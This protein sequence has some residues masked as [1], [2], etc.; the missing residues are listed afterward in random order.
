VAPAFPGATLEIDAEGEITHAWLG[1]AAPHLGPDRGVLAALGI[2]DAA[3][4]AAQVQMLL[5]STI[6]APADAWPIFVTDAPATLTRRDGQMLAVL[7]APVIT[8]GTITRVVVFVIPTAVARAEEED[9]AEVNRI[10]VDALALVDDSQAAL[11]HLTRDPHAR[12]CVHRMFRNLHTIKGSTRGPRLQAI[13]TL[14][15]D[16]EAVVEILQRTAEAEPHVLAQVG[17]HLQRLRAMIGTARPR[18]EVDD[19]MSELLGEC[20]PALVDLQLAI[21]RLLADDADAA[22]IAS[23]AIDQIQIAS[24]RAGMQ[25]LHQQCRFAAESV[26]AIARGAPITPARIDEIT[27]LDRQVELYA[28]VYRE[29][30]ASDRGPSLILTIASWIGSPE[31][32][33]G[34]F[35][36]LAEVI[37]QVGVPTLLEVLADPD[38]H[39][40]R[41]A[42]ALLVDGAAMFEP[43]R[44]RDEA[45][46]RF[47]RAQRELLAAIA[48]LAHDTPHAAVGE[49]RAIVERL[50][51]VPLAGLTR[52]LVR[53]TRT[54]AADLG[55]EVTAEIELGDLHA[56]PELVRV[57]G[58][59]LIH[60]V[61]NAIDHGI[62]LPGERVARGKCPHGTVHVEAYALDRR[63]LL[64]VWD[65]GRG[66]AIDRV[67]HIAIE[68]GWLSREAAGAAS[69]ATLLELLFRPGFSTTAAVTTV[70]GRGVGMDVIRS[71][72]EERGGSVTLS[73]TP[74]RGTELMI[75]LP[76][77]APAAASEADSTD[78]RAFT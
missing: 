74:G 26:E 51:W 38:P 75:D 68:R 66:V 56:A 18:D 32:R 10:C 36:G 30:A 9:P 16:T 47:E 25:A 37:S 49:L 15:H 41:C 17:S 54:L 43:A 5:A 20:R 27:L 2:D 39:G 12:P 72:A 45:T 76:L 42:R 55:K 40:A 62:E 8:R 24:E 61:R 11:L 22:A 48:V 29:I 77:A 28:A 33:D 53:M 50:G 4:S 34:S 63:I 78:A 69:D 13:S 60:V 35:A 52:R 57:L 21:T 14:A 6:G 59:I 46:Q 73:S 7:W 71:L 19:A 31:D 67:R 64:T 3:P 23:G 70:S 58:E 1:A 44:P 65:D